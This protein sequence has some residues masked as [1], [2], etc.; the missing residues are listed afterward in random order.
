[1][2]ITYVSTGAFVNIFIGLFI[3][4]SLTTRFAR[5]TENAEKIILSNTNEASP[6]TDEKSRK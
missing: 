5:D 4:E 1:M 6:H 2:L 3:M